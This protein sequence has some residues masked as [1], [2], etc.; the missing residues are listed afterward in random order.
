MAALQQIETPAG[1]IE[2]RWAGPNQKNAGLRDTSLPVLVF[3]HEGL[4]CVALWKDFPD[5]V[6]E[7]TGLPALV[8]SRIGYGGSSP[9]A[10][11]RP[12][13][14]MHE[15][16]EAGLPDLL[17]ALGIQS[18]ILIG[19]SDGAS[20]ALI[21]AGA[22]QREGLLG[23]A[24]LA[25]HVFCEEVSVR[26]IRAADKAYAEGELKARLAKYHGEN[27]DGAFR[28]WCDSWLNPDFRHWNIEA[29]VE[30][31]QV[32]VLAIQGEDDEYGTVAQVESIK[33]RAEADILLIPGCGHSPQRDQPAATLKAVVGFIRSLGF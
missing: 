13:T 21:Y 8:Y 16:G 28:G 32:P 1:R 22:K 31:I 26:S 25:P 30:R 7:A 15:E 33:E 2:Y 19:H 24:V 3:L 5:Q 23:V 12:I 20:I 17:A 27:V 18:H 6:A 9:C 29:Y 10:L 11:P 4:G 14:Y